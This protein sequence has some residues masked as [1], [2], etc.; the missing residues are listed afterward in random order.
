[1]GQLYF[2][3]KRCYSFSTLIPFLPITFSPSLL[4]HLQVLFSPFLQEDF[5]LQHF[6]A[7]EHFDLEEQDDDFVQP[8]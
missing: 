5:D 7:L 4:D 8:E 6:F 2:V 3:F 1:M